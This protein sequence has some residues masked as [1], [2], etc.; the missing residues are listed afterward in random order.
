MSTSHVRRLRLLGVGG[1]WNDDTA[2]G[3]RSRPELT[4]CDPHP[5]ALPALAEGP[6]LRS[7]QLRQYPV[8]GPGAGTNL[9]VTRAAG[10]RA[11]PALSQSRRGLM[12][13]SPPPRRRIKGTQ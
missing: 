11:Q 9:P 10:L 12:G 7:P 5:A 4:I 8:Q 13:S 2:S 6:F 3:D 1:R